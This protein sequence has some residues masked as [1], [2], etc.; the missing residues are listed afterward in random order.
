MTWPRSHGESRLEL[1]VLSS[2]SVFYLLFLLPPKCGVS[3]FTNG[4]G[5]GVLNQKTPPKTYPAVTI[6][7]P[8]TPA[9]V[10]TQR[11]KLIP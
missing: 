8:P 7:W 4:N 1:V 11:V 5:F 9:S 2:S 3:T 6:P 10:D